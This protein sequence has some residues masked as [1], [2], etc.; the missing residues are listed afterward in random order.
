MKCKKY[1]D[2]RNHINASIIHPT[3]TLINISIQWF[4]MFDLADEKYAISG[5]T[6]C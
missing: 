3:K 1:S 4:A 5:N 6:A 2:T